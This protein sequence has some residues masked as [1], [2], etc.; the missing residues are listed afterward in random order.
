M[1]VS[2]PIFL[3]FVTFESSDTDPPMITKEQC[4]PFGSNSLC[5]DCTKLYCPAL[6][7]AR[8][9]IAGKGSLASI[10]LVTRNEGVC[11]QED[12]VSRRRGIAHRAMV[13]RLTT[14]IWS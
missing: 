10:P 8:E 12:A 7:A 2:V 11:L 6:P 3:G 1:N 9:N 13:Y 4:T 5:R 14:Q